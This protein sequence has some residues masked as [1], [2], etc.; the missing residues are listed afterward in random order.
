MGG[1]RFSARICTLKKY[2]NLKLFGN[3]GGA[4]AKTNKCMLTSANNAHHKCMLTNVDN[5][6]QKCIHC[7]QQRANSMFDNLKMF[8][9]SRPQNLP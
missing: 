5:A 3:I 6:H 8:F 9:G 7:Q 4:M 1:T 2:L